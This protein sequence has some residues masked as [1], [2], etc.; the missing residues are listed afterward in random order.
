MPLHT[1]APH[2]DMGIKD[3]Y[4]VNFKPKGDGAL[5]IHDD[6]IIAYLQVVEILLD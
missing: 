4:G 2:S 3:S 6:D 5:D 1:Y